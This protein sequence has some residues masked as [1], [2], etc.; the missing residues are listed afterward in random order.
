M[1]NQE[2]AKYKE[3]VIEALLDDP[4]NPSIMSI[5]ID[6]MDNN[7]CRCPYLGRQGSFSHPIPQ[8]IIGVKEHGIGATFYRTFGTVTKGADITI[9]CILRKIE[10]WKRRNLKYPTKIYIQID[11]ATDNANKYLLGMLELLVAKKMA[12]TIVLSR[13]PVGHTHEDIDALFG[14]IYNSFKY[15]PAET[16]SRY[17]KVI[18]DAFRKIGFNPKVEDVYCIPDY[19]DFIEPCVDKDL[20]NMHRL[21]Q[22]QLQFRFEAVKPDVYFPHG[23]KT[24]FK[25]FSSEQVVE[26]DIGNPCD[27][28]TLVGQLT[29]LE[30]KTTYNTWMPEPYGINSLPERQGVEGTHFL[31]SLPTAK[32][33]K[34]KEF[35]AESVELIAHNIVEIKRYY[36]METSS[37]MSIYDEWALWHLT[38]A[39]LPGDEGVDGYVHRILNVRCLA[40]VI[41]IPIQIDLLNSGPIENVNWRITHTYSDLHDPNFVWPDQLQAAMNSVSYNRNLNPPPPRLSS[42]SDQI[43]KENVNTFKEKV[44]QYYEEVKLKSLDYLKS[45]VSNQVKYDGERV[46][47]Q[48]N[49]TQAVSKME[50]WGRYFTGTIF[51]LVGSLYQSLIVDNY[52]SNILNPENQNEILSNRNVQEI[53]VYFAINSL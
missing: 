35:V 38:K 24:T 30:P 50:T 51:K 28:I 27:N 49:K 31:V 26:F 9:Y 14:T 29:G 39:P 16:L 7:K 37:N 48:I 17:K 18:I 11:G 8:H 12:K 23:V 36:M 25:A 43:L 32:E 53:Q 40:N 34:F 13:L 52:F 41:F 21:E 2:R 33:F 3:R 6:G 47:I 46:A 1:F 20:S 42:T 22:T 45:K 44:V 4:R 5:I 19:K 10:E 15:S